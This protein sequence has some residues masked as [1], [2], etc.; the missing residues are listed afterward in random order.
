MT[1]ASIRQTGERVR[2]I[3]LDPPFAYGRQAVVLHLDTGVEERVP[4]NDLVYA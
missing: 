2:V 3:L 1:F 4:A